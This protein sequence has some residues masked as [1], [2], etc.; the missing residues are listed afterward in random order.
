MSI[1]FW[2]EFG[3]L[4]RYEFLVHEQGSNA[5]NFLVM[6]F[7]DFGTVWFD[8]AASGNG[9]YHSETYTAGTPIHIEVAF[10]SELG[11]YSVWMNDVRVVH[12]RAHGITGR[13]IGR[14]IFGESFD[15]DTN[16]RMRVDRIRVD[17]LDS[18]TTGAP[19]G[20]LPAL[21][22]IAMRAA[23]NPFNP[24]TAVRFSLP[25][26]GQVQ[27]DVVDLRGRRV[28]MLLGETLAAG[29]H[30]VAWRGTD[31]GGRAMASGVYEAVL[32]VDG[33]VRQRL[34]LTLIK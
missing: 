24:A 33:Q 15:T 26:A 34:P 5:E 2:V 13:G 31:A 25:H 14:L 29:D 17:T 20:P 22:T 8:D 28:A 1:S 21:Q 30:E 16:G 9:H 27:L 4:E 23:P 12:R 19:D 7:V 10:Y 32:R 11:L 6:N 3:S 18:P